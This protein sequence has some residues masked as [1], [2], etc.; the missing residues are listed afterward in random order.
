MSYY[1][2]ISGPGIAGA[3]RL[4]HENG[5]PAATRSRLCG[6]TFRSREA[7]DEHRARVAAL[8]PAYTLETR[9][10]RA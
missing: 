9:A 2:S 3:Q 10:E 5:V 6:L 8:C 4:T 1:V 7:A